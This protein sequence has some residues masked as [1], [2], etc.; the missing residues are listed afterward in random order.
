M[1]NT[2]NSLGIFRGIIGFIVVP[3]WASVKKS[4]KNLKLGKVLERG[5]TTQTPTI[6]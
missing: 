2:T 5:R 1:K 3:Y 4:L 6:K